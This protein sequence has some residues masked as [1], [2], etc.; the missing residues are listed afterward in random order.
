[1]SSDGVALEVPAAFFEHTPYLSEQAVVSG[2]LSFLKAFHKFS[3]PDA[4]L[5]HP[6]VRPR[7]EKLVGG[8]LYGFLRRIWNLTGPIAIEDAVLYAEGCQ[9]H[10]CGPKGTGAMLAVDLKQQTVT[11]GIR[12]DGEV[13]TFSET[14]GRLPKGLTEWAKQ[15]P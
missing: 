13:K 15:T 4:V 9:A 2:D 8:W 7:I 10:E 11:V 6:S 12:V 5:R 3:V 1:M 14:P